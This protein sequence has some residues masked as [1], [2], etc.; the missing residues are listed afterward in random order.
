MK[1]MLTALA[2]ATPILSLPALPAAQDRIPDATLRQHNESCIAKC[3]KTRSYAACASTCGCMTNEMSR[4]WSARDY[5]ARMRRLSQ[6]AND[7]A[8]NGEMG[9]MAGYCARRSTAPD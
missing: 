3:T 8:V 5:D 9:R 1:P 6:N 4:H 2:I 7:A